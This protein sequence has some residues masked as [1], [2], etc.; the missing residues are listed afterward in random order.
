MVGGGTLDTMLSQFV[1]AV[2]EGPPPSMK[3]KLTRKPDDGGPVLLIAE[4]EDDEHAVKFTL[5]LKY[6]EANRKT[7]G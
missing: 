3:V 4:V 5:E 1:E 7:A 6:G 2:N